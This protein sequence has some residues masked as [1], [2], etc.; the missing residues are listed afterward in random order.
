RRFGGL[1][2]TDSAPLERWA[3]SQFRQVED[4]LGSALHGLAVQEVVFLGPLHPF[5]LAAGR[6]KTGLRYDLAAEVFADVPWQMPGAGRII[7]PAH[8]LLNPGLEIVS[9][10][11]QQVE[12]VLDVLAVDLDV[13]LAR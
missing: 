10:Q 11:A 2:F 4:E 12:A 5:Y 1:G 13:D 9:V 3:V 7:G 8:L 6:S